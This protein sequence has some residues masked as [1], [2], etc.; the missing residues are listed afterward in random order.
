MTLLF[1]KLIFIIALPILFFCS[2]CEETYTKKLWNNNFY[3]EVFYYFL[4]SKDG[5]F[6]VFLGDEFHYVFN[7]YSKIMQKLLLWKNS[8]KLFINNDESILK[9]SANNQVS[10]EVVIDIDKSFISNQNLSAIYSLGFEEG[11]EKFSLKFKIF[12]QRY[13]A[14]TEINNF[15]PRLSVPYNIRIF[16]NLTSGQKIV[17][18]SLSPLTIV[19]DAIMISGKILTFPFNN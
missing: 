14:K 9:I 19:L 8:K 17:K 2:G 16:Y 12:G 18:A 15:T 11:K 4:I 7:D 5:E 13:L 3:N 1:K 6:V 10:G